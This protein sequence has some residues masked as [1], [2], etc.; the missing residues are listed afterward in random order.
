MPLAPTRYLPSLRSFAV[1]CVAGARIARASSFRCELDAT[2]PAGSVH[3]EAHAGSVEGGVLL[4]E[5]LGAL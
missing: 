3:P 2:P 1:S 4:A 5:R